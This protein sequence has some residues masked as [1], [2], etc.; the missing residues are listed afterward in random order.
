MRKKEMVFFTNAK[1]KFAGDVTLLETK[2][3]RK[4]LQSYSF[5]ADVMKVTYKQV[6]V[7][8]EALT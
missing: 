6:H 3:R 5:W 7:H 1:E 8:Q 4:V 2:H